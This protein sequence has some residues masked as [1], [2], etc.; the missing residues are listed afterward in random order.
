[1]RLGTPIRDAA[2]LGR[3]IRQT[4]KQQGL[5]LETLAGLCGLSVRFLSELENGRETCSLVRVL[6][7]LD[8]L[9]IELTAE[10]PETA[11]P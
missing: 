3:L 7:V 2:T 5:T 8:A 11:Q 10:P 6:L 4:R 1:M 9:G